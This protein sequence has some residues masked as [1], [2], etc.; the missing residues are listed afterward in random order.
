VKAFFDTNVLIYA[1]SQDERKRRAEHILR[2]GGVISA[3]VLNEFTHVARRKL[4]LDW[5]VIELA[6]MH[7]HDVFDEVRP[8]TAQTHGAALTLARDHGFAFYD[9][10]IVAAAIEAGCDTLYS[11]DMQHGRTIHDLNVLNPFAEGASV[12]RQGTALGLPE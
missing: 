7:F 10:L 12:A 4:D 9:A 1:V 8:L 2:S 11:E 6:V 5:A 3:Q